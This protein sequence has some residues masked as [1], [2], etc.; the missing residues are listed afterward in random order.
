MLALFQ[1]NPTYLL[2]VL[3][4]GL[5]GIGFTKRN[6]LSPEQKLLW[7]EQSRRFKFDTAAMI[8]FLIL[9][10]SR[11]IYNQGLV[12]LLD[13][14]A[15]IVMM[16]FGLIEFSAKFRN[17]KKAGFS[18]RVLLLF[19]ISYILLFVGLGLFLALT[20]AEILKNGWVPISDFN[21][22]P[23]FFSALFLATSLF[24]R[25]ELP[26]LS[27]QQRHNLAKLEFDELQILQRNYSLAYFIIAAIVLG[28]S[29]VFSNGLLGIFLGF[30]LFVALTALLRFN[31][32][33]DKVQ[34]LEVYNL[35]TEYINRTEQRAK[36][37]TFIFG[38]FMISIPFFV[39]LGVI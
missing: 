26:E 32:I 22:M 14:T 10:Y 28:F 33:K 15:I 38:I 29:I 1:N 2:V 18:D 23:V 16:A 17:F 30:L 11:H 39:W 31:F 34:Y 27:E 36:R 12:N 35:P 3:I 20:R 6:L 9:F 5:L 8:L 7:L 19:A 25:T 4:P 13:T 21:F 37:M 24:S